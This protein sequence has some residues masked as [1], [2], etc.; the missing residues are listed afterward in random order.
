MEDLESLG[1]AD[2][3]KKLLEEE[4]HEIG[5]H[6]NTLQPKKQNIKP[7]TITTSLEKGQII[8]MSTNDFLEQ[9]LEKDNTGYTLQYQ[10]WYGQWKEIPA[11]TEYFE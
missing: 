2:T 6:L 5:S 10:T 9:E 11:V 8:E 4:Y 7:N 3:V 1:G